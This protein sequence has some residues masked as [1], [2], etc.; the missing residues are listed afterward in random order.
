MHTMRSSLNGPR[1]TRAFRRPVASLGLAGLI[2]MA[3]LATGCALYR[4]DRCWLPA[5]Q[6]AMARE[7]FIQSGSLDIVGQRMEKLQ[8][9]RC[10]RN[11]TLYRLQKEF[12]VL[13]EE[14]PAAGDS[15]Q[16]EQG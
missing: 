2:L 11:E 8:W 16:P 1:S 12:E 7:M 6:Y 13:P 5:E 4:N 15:D 9:R 3:G 14:L 10:R